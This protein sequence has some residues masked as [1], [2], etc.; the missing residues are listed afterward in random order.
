MNLLL[1]AVN[2]CPVIAPFP[3]NLGIRF[4]LYA[5]VLLTHVKIC[6]KFWRFR[7][8][9]NIELWVRS[10]INSY[11]LGSFCLIEDYKPLTTLLGPKSSIPA[12][13]AARLQR[14]QCHLDVMTFLVYGSR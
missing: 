5:S 10:F 8:H 11:M 14:K 4:T 9:L 6:C 7:R 13:A 3:E 2:E 1:R 12:L